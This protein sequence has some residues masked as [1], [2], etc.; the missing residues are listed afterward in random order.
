[1]SLDVYLTYHTTEEIE[2]ERCHGKGQVLPDP[3]DVFE[4]NITH[5]LNRMAKEA[6][7]SQHLWHPDAI[8]ITKAAELIEPLTAGLALLR[9]DP[10]RFKAFDASNGWGRYGH[11]V[12]FV[13]E[14]L[15]ACK[16]HPDADV[17]VSR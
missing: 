6:G 10:A 13:E 16:R 1:M 5:N 11:L 3:D 14:Y 8:G 17:S 12:T 9:S 2:C 15:A 7:I 4:S